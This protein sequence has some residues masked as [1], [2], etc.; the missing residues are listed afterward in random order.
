MLLE[1]LAQVS[2]LSASHFIHSPLPTVWEG[3]WSLGL[4][5]DLG[6]GAFLFLVL[7]CLLHSLSLVGCKAAAPAGSWKPTHLSELS[8]QGVFVA[9]ERA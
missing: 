8:Q 3:L 5:A 2:S 1:I 4:I 7:W 6:T 9:T